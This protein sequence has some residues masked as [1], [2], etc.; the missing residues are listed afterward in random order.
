MTMR[1]KYLWRHPSG[2]WYVRIKGKYFRIM[3]QEGTADFDREYWEI[4]SGKRAVTKTSWAALIDA[5]KRT[6]KWAGFAPRYRDDLEA[7]FEYLKKKIGHV[8]VSKLTQADIY[9]A[10]EKHRHNVN[11]AN[12]IP[13]AIRMLSKLAIRKRW[14]IDNPAIGIEPFKVPDDRKKPHIPWPDWAVDKMREEGKPLPRLIFEIGL[15]SVQRPGDWV[16]FTW[17]DYDGEMLK[18]TQNKTGKVLQLPCTD[19]LKAALD[20]ARASLGFEPDPSRHILTRPDGSAMSYY[21]MARIMLAERKRLGLVDFDQHALRYRGVMDLAWA[22]CTDDEI[23]SY[24]GHTTKAM[25]AKYAGEARQIMQARQAA[26]K[27]K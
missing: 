10:M 4:R 24:S 6:D 20:Q 12:Y 1:K 23:A 25:I 17:G 27:R 11:F 16:G 9:D 7:V 15:G 21:S 18:L 13:I 22:G 5:F 3:A 2:R 14:R 19:N 8:D 26:A